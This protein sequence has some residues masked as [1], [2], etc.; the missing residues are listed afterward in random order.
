MVNYDWEKKSNKVM[1]TWYKN[2]IQMLPTGYD[3]ADDV[4][5]RLEGKTDYR[6]TEK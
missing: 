2:D 3:W 5:Q 4:A 6:S 1:K